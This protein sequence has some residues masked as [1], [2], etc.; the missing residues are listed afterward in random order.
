MIER[1]STKDL[2][3]KS[4]KDLAKTKSIDKITIKEI[5]ENCGLSKRLFYNYFQ[6]KRELVLYEYTENISS[7]FCEENK[8]LS[9]N[10]LMYKALKKITDNYDYY[11]N[12]FLVFDN[13]SHPLGSMK[14]AANDA[15]EEFIKLKY[16]LD[17]LSEEESFALKIYTY[18]IWFYGIEWI[19][20]GMPINAKKLSNYL[21]SSL[22]CVITKYMN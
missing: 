11:K 4:L 21:E 3:V 16:N 13:S 22:P 14:L 9:W 7:V 2:L 8:D 5:T 15:F 19:T 17:E 6:D 18:G 1:I 10:V 12:A 20:K